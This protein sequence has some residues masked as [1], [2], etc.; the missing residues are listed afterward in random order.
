MAPKGGL[1]AIMPCGG[2]ING[3]LAPGGIIGGGPA[4]GLIIGPVA[5]MPMDGNG[6]IGP[7]ADDGIP[8]WR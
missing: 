6:G 4:A 2:G 1:I 7:E 5:I 8:A 3:G